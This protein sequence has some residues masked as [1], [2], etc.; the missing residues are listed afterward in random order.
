[1]MAGG[2]WVM[3]ID[4]RSKSNWG[5]IM[6]ELIHSKLCGGK[7][8]PTEVHSIITV[9]HRQLNCA[10]QKEVEELL[11]AEKCVEDEVNFLACRQTHTWHC[12]RQ[13]HGL[14]VTEMEAVF[15]FFVVVTRESFVVAGETGVH[16]RLYCDRTTEK[17]KECE[18]T[19]GKL[20]FLATF[21]V[22]LTFGA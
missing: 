20:I 10:E 22:A 8:S 4:N 16:G 1:M 7:L 11:I 3:R 15:H 9:E 12:S 21:K 13:D 17:K 14:I 19:N 18:R 5:G 6:D 2:E